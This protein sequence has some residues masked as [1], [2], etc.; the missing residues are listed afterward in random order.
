MQWP[1]ALMNV[2]LVLN[3]FNFSECKLNINKFTRFQK[4]PLLFSIGF[5]DGDDA[6]ILMCDDEIC[7]F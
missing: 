6:C 5:V 7:G 2:A 4:Y 1:C 3:Y